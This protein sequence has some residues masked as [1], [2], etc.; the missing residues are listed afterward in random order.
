MSWPPTCA[1]TGPGEPGPLGAALE[2]DWQP[3]LE[4]KTSFDEAVRA[5]VRDASR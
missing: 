2:L 5:L 4:S 1:A 3:Y